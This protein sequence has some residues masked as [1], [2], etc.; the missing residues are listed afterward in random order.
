MGWHLP[1]EEGNPRATRSTSTVRL[2]AA[3]GQGGMSPLGRT[4]ASKALSKGKELAWVFAR[5]FC[6]CQSPPGALCP[7]LVLS[8]TG[9]PQL[10]LPTE[11]RWWKAAGPLQTL[12]G[13]RA[14]ALTMEAGISEQLK[15]LVSSGPPPSRATRDL[16]KA[17]LLGAGPPGQP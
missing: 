8:S 5:S 14:P 10:S 16:D 4:A 2:R 13:R 7:D 6:F 17:L 1:Q 11:G 12:P 9:S 3:W 15:T